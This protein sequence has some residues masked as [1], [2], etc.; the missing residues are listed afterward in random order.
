VVHF[1]PTALAEQ[2]DTDLAS[3]VVLNGF[4]FVESLGVIDPVELV[5][6]ILQL[7]ES[8]GSD[9]L[10]SHRNR[11]WWKRSFSPCVAGL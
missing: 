6:L 11:V 7:F 2:S 1:G 5:G 10:L 4:L 3:F 9:C 8:C